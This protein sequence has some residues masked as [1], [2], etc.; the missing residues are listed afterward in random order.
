MGAA[1]TCVILQ[2]Q[3]G[4]Q[5]W[6]FIILELREILEEELPEASVGRG[7]HAFM[8]RNLV[9]DYEAESSL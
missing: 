3:E 5:Q 1:G 4:A 9:V 2:S 7:C 6:P 8:L